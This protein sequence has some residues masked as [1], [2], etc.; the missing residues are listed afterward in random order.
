MLRLMA[1]LIF[2]F[3]PCTIF[4][5]INT[6]ITGVVTD[7]STGIALPNSNVSVIGTTIGAAADTDGTFIINNLPYGTYSIKATRIGYKEVVKR[8]VKIHSTSK[9]IINF[10]LEPKTIELSDVEIEASRLSD[11]YPEEVSRICIQDINPRG[12]PKIPG[13]LDDITRVVHIYGSAIP[14]SDYTSFFAVRGG[15]PDQNL[16][17]FN[18]V[19]VPNPYRLRL[20]MGGG[21]SIFNPYTIDNVY[22]HVGGFPAEYGNFLSS[23]LEVNAKSGRRDRIVSK[24]SVNILDATAVIEGP[25][26]NRK[27]SWIVS[28]RRTY[29]DLAANRYLEHQAAYPYTYDLTGKIVY[30]INNRLQLSVNSL[31]CI[32]GTDVATE[33]YSGVGIDEQSK[34]LL[35]SIHMDNRLSQKMSQHFIFSQYTEEFSYNFYSNSNLEKKVEGEYESTVHDYTIKENFI[36]RFNK[37]HRINRGINFSTYNTAMMFNPATKSIALNL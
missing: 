19:V 32:E 2:A 36:F 18:G 29:F 27:G 37:N 13:S 24:A 23:I 35:L 31:K 11:K 14:S 4:A 30:D 1:F 8:D 5:H 25:L 9:L 7:K 20:V 28:G 6:V 34:I 10:E 17:V 21:M 3:L 12:V 26:L 33:S 22:L 15:S 16:V